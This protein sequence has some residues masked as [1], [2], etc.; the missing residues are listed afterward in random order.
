MSPSKESYDPH[1]FEPLFAAEEKHFW[2]VARNKVIS[3]LARKAL[4]DI[5]KPAILEVGCG[6]GNVL[7][8]LEKEFPSANLTGMDL[9]S[10]G[11]RFARQRTQCR[12]IQADL[13]SPPL[14]MKFDL[15]GMFDVLEH[16]KEDQSVVR[17][18]FHL[19]KP[20]GLFMVT[21]PA[22]PRLWSYFDLASRH[23]RRYTLDGLRQTILQA[24]F[25]E[26]FL[27]PYIAITYPAIWLGR[28]AIDTA[29]ASQD[30]QVQHHAEK[31][32][33]IIP[34][35]NEIVCAVLSLESAWL[36]YGRKLPFGSSLVMLARKPL[37]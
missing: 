21:V 1:Y 14:K 24:G 23:V 26:E 31:E 18:I 12:L 22:D 29:I 34:V 8:S 3:S 10:E 16:I 2:F 32:F 7:Q 4:V 36:S 19:V 6:T 9:F 30:L 37:T 13:A 17:Q 20:G 11:L 35:V 15:V 25:I 27:S 5:N 28:K 33:R